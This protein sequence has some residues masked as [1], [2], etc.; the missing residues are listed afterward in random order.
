[1]RRAINLLG[2]VGVSLTISAIVLT[3]LTTYQ[4]IYVK[5]FNDYSTLQWCIFFTMLIWAIKMID[6]KSR[7]KNIIYPIAC[8]LIAVVT[9]FFMYLG[10]Y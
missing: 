1:M 4:F 8:G 5:H 9:I 2:W 3:L 7:F 10:V 6:L